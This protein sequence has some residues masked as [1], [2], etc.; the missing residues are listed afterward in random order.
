MLPMLIEHFDLLQFEGKYDEAVDTLKDYIT[1]HKAMRHHKPL[2]E[3]MIDQEL[4]NALYSLYQL[5][6][7]TH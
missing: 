4:V 3:G 1:K 5:T 2:P 7:E 6:K